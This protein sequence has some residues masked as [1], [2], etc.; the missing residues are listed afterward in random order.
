[1]QSRE[2]EPESLTD[3]EREILQLIWAGFKN[4]EI[5]QRLKISMKTVEAHRA[6]IDE[7]AAGVECRSAVEDGNSR[8]DDQYSIGY[9]SFSAILDI[10]CRSGGSVARVIWVYQDLEE[11]NP[12]RA[13]SLDDCISTRWHH[14]FDIGIVALR[15]SSAAA[16]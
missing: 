9:N 7:K 2:R 4:N 10:R 15:D 13:Y 11:R 16:R 1:M 5:A 3:R 14:V 8:R 6:T 12:E